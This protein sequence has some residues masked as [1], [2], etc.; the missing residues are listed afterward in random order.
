MRRRA[1]S[2]LVLI[3]T[4]MT[5]LVA[6]PDAAH[7][8]EAGFTHKSAFAIRA[9]PIGISLFSDTGYRLPLWQR[10]ESALFSGTHIAV[11]ATTSLSPAFGWVG[12]YVELLPIA[13]LRL[14]ASAQLM[15]FYGN[16]GYL[17]RS[18][19]ES[20][21]WSSQALSAA[22]SDKLGEASSGWLFLAQAT[23]QIRVGR[24][25]AT[26]ET[27]LH[28][29]Q[30][31][32]ETPYYEPYYDLAFAPSDFFWITRPTLGYLIGEDLS[33]GYLLLGARWERAA[34]RQTEI[35]R[36]TA[37]LVF[38]WKIPSALF[39]WGN[40]TLAGFGGVFIDHPNRG[41]ISPYF[42]TQAVVEF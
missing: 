26:A 32:M 20:L 18:G 33:K 22:R 28:W 13:V 12:P 1:Q 14:R 19:E 30:M 23:P 39:S 7:S 5:L 9:T 34:T 41:M 25:V 11:G 4:L 24:F 16:L 42:G 40:P 27:T 37:G 10:P 15:S 6:A 21:D 2:V 31:D 17:Y 38:S 3:L 36:D 35:I 29:V 8:Q